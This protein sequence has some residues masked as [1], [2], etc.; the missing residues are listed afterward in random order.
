MDMEIARRRGAADGK[1]Q[2]T[3]DMLAQQYG[4]A[5]TGTGAVDAPA[6]AAT[7]FF[8]RVKAVPLEECKYLLN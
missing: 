2:N 1:V 7:D 8:G 5:R 6:A 4:A 3:A